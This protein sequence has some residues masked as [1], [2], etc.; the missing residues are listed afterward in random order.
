MSHQPY[1][2][3]LIRREPLSSEQQHELNCHLNECETCSTLAGALVNLEDVFI[4]SR[5]PEP[6]PGFT[7][8]WQARLA[9]Y[10]QKRQNRNLWLMTIGLFSLAGFI[11]LLL[12]L[13]HLQNLNIGYELS[14]MIARISRFVAE[15]RLSVNM[16]RSITSAL[17][18]IIPIMFLL[19]AS[20]LLSV[21][22]L[23]LTWFRAIIRLYSP[24]QER[25]NLS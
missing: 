2:A 3:Y 7:Q 20:A 13:F 24:I 17:P 18:L 5:T 16:F 25:G 4:N 19:I 21:T 10:R 11:M 14:L 6:A 15:V 23:T 8:R 22:A 9:G 1:E 12:F